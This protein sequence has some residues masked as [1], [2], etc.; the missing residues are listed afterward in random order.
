MGSFSCCATSQI[1][2]VSRLKGLSSTWSGQGEQRGRDGLQGAVCRAAGRCCNSAAAPAGVATGP[3]WPCAR[4]GSAR[5]TLRAADMWIDVLHC[6]W[7]PAGD[8]WG[9]PARCPCTSLTSPRHPMPLRGWCTRTGGAHT[10]ADECTNRSRHAAVLRRLCTDGAHA[11]AGGCANTQARRCPSGCVQRN[12]DKCPRVC[13]LPKPS[14][15]HQC[16]R[17]GSP[18]HGTLVASG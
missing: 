4:G 14:V 8:A 16:A 3:G 6:S 10:A 1:R 5:S 13:F 12:P 11:A 7:P 9:A 2:S 15:N 17:D 18:Q